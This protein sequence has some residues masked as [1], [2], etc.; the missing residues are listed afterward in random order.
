[1][2]QKFGEDSKGMAAAMAG[3]AAGK[4]MEVVV[5]FKEISRKIAGPLLEAAKKLLTVV[6]FA[7]Q[8]WTNFAKVISL[9][10]RSIGDVLMTPFRF[11]KETFMWFL[12]NL[13]LV[14]VSALMLSKL[15]LKDLMDPV[16]AAGKVGAKALAMAAYATL[17]IKAMKLPENVQLLTDET[18]KQWADI[19]GTGKEGPFK[20][21]RVLED[22]LGH[23]ATGRVSCQRP[24]ERSRR[25]SRSSIWMKPGRSFRTRWTAEATI[26]S[27]PLM[28]SRI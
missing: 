2:L 17:G 19:L 10:L 25:N 7:G 21:F 6:S 8:S 18:K 15:S 28:A 13:H 24:R 12:E 23:S 16:A 27:G 4:W 1:M 26:K 9:S 20:N 14:L 11:L 5:M 22:E 3:T